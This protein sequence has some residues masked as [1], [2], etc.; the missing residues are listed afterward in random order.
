[1]VAG[2]R[3][4]TGMIASLL[5]LAGCGEA[6]VVDA[7][8]DMRSARAIAAWLDEAGFTC[9]GF[10]P[11]TDVIGAREDGTCSHGETTVTITTFNSAEQM[12]TITE[13]FKDLQSG[14]IVQGDKW[15]VGVDNR[16]Q[17]EE[18]MNWIGG[19]VQ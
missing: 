5:L 8:V 7:D 11:N 10:E 1:M 9:E 4:T 15:Q 13:A 14:V 2:M 3:R 16:E 19:E 6:S 17:A 18:V 12:E